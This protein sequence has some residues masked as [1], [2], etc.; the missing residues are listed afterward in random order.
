M[1][2]FI[3]FAHYLPAEYII[4]AVVPKWQGGEQN[5]YALLSAAYL[6]SLMIADSLKIESVAFPLL[7]AGNN[8]FD[9]R[10]AYF[11]AK[12]TVEN[13]EPSNNLK[14]VYLT[15]Y[16]KTA[17]ALLLTLGED[18][19]ETPAEV[20]VPVKAGKHHAMAAKGAVA[21]KGAAAAVAGDVVGVAKKLWDEHKEEIVRIG[22]R[23]AFEAGK[24]ALIKGKDKE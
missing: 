19:A 22:I 9:P 16:S 20:L 5:E 24:R 15:I 6:S 23:M 11:V 4:H 17:E 21:V 8:G 10:V 18:I 2:F 1:A 3:I 12:N 13:F 7:A 14:K